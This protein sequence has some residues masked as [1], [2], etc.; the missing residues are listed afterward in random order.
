MYDRFLRIARHKNR[1]YPVGKLRGIGF[2]VPR[3]TGNFESG[4]MPH[5]IS[6]DELVGC[7]F[8]EW[9]PLLTMQNLTAPAALALTAPS[10][11]FSRDTRGYLLM[12]AVETEDWEQ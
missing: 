3:L 12:G 10:K 1:N 4:R 6:V 11:S 7:F 9:L 8:V 2:A 5:K